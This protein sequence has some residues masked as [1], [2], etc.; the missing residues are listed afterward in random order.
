MQ[1]AYITQILLH[2]E[3]VT[4]QEACEVKEW[5]EAMDEDM[6]ALVKNDTWELVKLPS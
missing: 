4:F 3:L 6:S 5:Q 1:Y 2:D